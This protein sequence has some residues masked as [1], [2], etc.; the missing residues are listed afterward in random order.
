[1]AVLR[2][3]LAKTLPGLA[4]LAADAEVFLA[5]A[6]LDGPVAFK[7]Q[8]ALEEGIRNIIE[9]AGGAPECPIQVEIQAGPGRVVIVLEDDGQPFDPASAPPFDPARA[10]A[11]R[12][13]N[14]MGVHLL[15]QLMDEIQYER[16]GSVNRLRL[17]VAC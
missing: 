15:R 2:R 5:G 11:G 12:E 7:V 17:V 9:H 13:P 16:L 1:M 8:L 4:G 14:G 3:S 6:G 10:L